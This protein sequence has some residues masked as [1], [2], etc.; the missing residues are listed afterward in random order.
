MKIPFLNLARTHEPIRD[1]LLQAI[2]SILSSS[3][4]ISGK[5]VHDFEDDFKRFVGTRFAVALNTG[6]SALH[7]ALVA[8]GVGEGDEVITTPST[9]VATTAAITYTGA[10][11]VFVDTHPEEWT[12][13]LNQVES[14]LS[15]NTKAILPVHL[16]GRM[17]NMKE[18]GLFARSHGLKIIED[19]CQAHGADNEGVRP[20]EFSDAAAFSFYPGKNLGG[21]GEGGALVTNDSVVDERVRLLRNWGSD[22]RYQHLIHAY[23][24]RMDSI[25][26]AVLGIKLKHLDLW[27]QKRRLVAD[28]YYKHL[29]NIPGISLPAKNPGHVYHIFAIRTQFREEVRAALR[30]ATVEFSCHY[31]IP[32]HL[33][34]A[35]SSLGYRRGDFPVAEQLANQWISLPIDPGMI[36]EEVEFIGN[37]LR[38]ELAGLSA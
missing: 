37:V 19:A 1:E 22:V 24:Y 29:S 34:P 21:I 11:P 30:K 31:P 26:G 17:C 13:D 35:Y 2:S 10:K 3:D 28:W 4:F 12:I 36:E 6:T 32:V 9:F 23:N 18:L 27:T 7:L 25:Q 15:E 14:V 20:G 16:H 5:P 8:C 33:Q 38:T